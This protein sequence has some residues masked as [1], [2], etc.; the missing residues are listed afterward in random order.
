MMVYR[1]ASNISIRGTKSQNLNVSHRLSI[2]FAQSIETTC[3]VEN[4]AVVG[5]A[6]TGDAQTTSEWPIILLSAKV[7]LV[8]D[9]SL[10]TASL[11]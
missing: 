4:E 7:C 11:I 1:Q 3:S 2:V 9:G 6:P 10:P 5:A 8:L